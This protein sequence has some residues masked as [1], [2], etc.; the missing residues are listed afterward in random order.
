MIRL[1]EF[2]KG[3]SIQGFD[4]VTHSLAIASLIFPIN[5]FFLPNLP[6]IVSPGKGSS[7]F[8]RVLSDRTEVGP[9]TIPTTRTGTR[10]RHTTTR[11][12]GILETGPRTGTFR[13]SSTA[14]VQSCPMAHL[15]T[16]PLQGP[17]CNMLRRR[18][19][20]W[21]NSETCDQSH[22]SVYA[23]VAGLSLLAWCTGTTVNP[24]ALVAFKAKAFLKN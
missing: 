12:G 19:F 2:D 11:L 17:K 23:M 18:S 24:N 1:K 14:M 8:R 21:L 9:A 6:K 4:K 13:L 10:R 15:L 22:V 16:P 20:S 3:F 5:V 7:W